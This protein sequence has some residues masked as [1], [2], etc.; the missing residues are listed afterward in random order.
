MTTIKINGRVF[1][2]WVR[3]DVCIDFDSH[4]ITVE[5]RYETKVRDW[6]ET[7]FGKQVNIEISED[8]STGSFDAELKDLTLEQP[9]LGGMLLIAKFYATC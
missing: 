1:E 5:S 4:T 6:L 2:N 8:G 9:N 3:L 7:L